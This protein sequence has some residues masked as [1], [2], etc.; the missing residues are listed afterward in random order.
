MTPLLSRK[1]DYEVRLIPPLSTNYVARRAQSRL[2]KPCWSQSQA[3]DP[4][5]EGRRAELV[6][7][8][9][10]WSAVRAPASALT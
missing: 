8:T 4:G 1:E 5:R 3:R 2:G 6:L 10:T 7:S 9:R